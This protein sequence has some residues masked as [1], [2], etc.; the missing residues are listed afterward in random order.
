VRT[1]SLRMVAGQ[2]CR[3]IGWTLLGTMF[4]GA[5]GFLEQKCPPR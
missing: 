2:Q 3:L 5:P 1:A 4:A